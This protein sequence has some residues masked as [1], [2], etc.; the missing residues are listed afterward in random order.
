[1]AKR[2]SRGSTAKCFAAILMKAPEV[3]D[4][5]SALTSPS[6]AELA[7]ANENP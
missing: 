5:P 4:V 6:T 3:F 7:L 2:L 1:V